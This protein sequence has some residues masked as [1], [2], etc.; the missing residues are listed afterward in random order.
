MRAIRAIT[1]EALEVLSRKFEGLHSKVGAL[2]VVARVAEEDIVLVPAHR[3]PRKRS[4][5]ALLPLV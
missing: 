4:G 2:Q 5:L 1:D 3:A